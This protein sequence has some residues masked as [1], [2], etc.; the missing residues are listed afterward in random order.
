MTTP[1]FAIVGHPNKGKSS[2]VSTL[3]QDESVAISSIPGTTA[4]NRVYPMSVDG[5][6]L[7]ELIDTPGF[8]R[9]RAAL[10]W[11]HDHAGSAVDRAAT[12]RRFVEQYAGD[13]RFTA[14][15]NL[16][17]P[18]LEGAGIL[19]VVDGSRP[20]GE[21]YEA[22]MEILRWTGQPSLALINMI[23][24]SDYSD[25]WK[26]ALGQYFRIVR[27][28]DAFTADF[29]RRVQLLLA[30]GEI[31]EEWRDALGKAVHILREEQAGRRKLAAR[32]IA[33]MLARMITHTRRQRL[34][35]DEQADGIDDRLLRDYKHDLAAMEQ[36]C[37]DEVEQIY[38]HKKLVRH[39]PLV[40]LLDEDLF[41]RQTWMLFGL[42]RRQLIATGAIGGAAAGGMIDLAVHGTSLL[43]GSGL[44]ALAGGVSA[45]F[46]SDRIASV[47][48]LGHSL[49]GK[50]L[51]IGPMRNI[52]FPYVALGRAL[53]HKRMVEQR[54]HAH[55]GPLELTS[56][57]GQLQLTNAA[58]RRR[59]EK[60]FSRLRKQETGRTDLITSLAHLIEK[61]SEDTD[62]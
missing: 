62:R 28:F 61:I 41:S 46:T 5:T 53:L 44:G 32:V 7:Y 1:V 21:D 50:E 49:G 23:G 20:F 26:K 38:N 54:T 17:R 43:L 15:C 4:E 12:V 6:V 18:V 2:I 8:Q 45:W 58:T 3:S 36:D 11:I 24:D 56:E 14:E 30:F 59:F 35:A 39:E 55:R 25:D 48:V 52:N 60:L 10:E 57:P 34:T 31:R 27:I 19:Y 42:T 37:R 13:P 51:S 9:A 40:Q 47:K 33:E 22:E 16:L 29:D